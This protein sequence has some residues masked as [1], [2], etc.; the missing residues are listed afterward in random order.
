MGTL[1]KKFLGFLAILITVNA[2]IYLGF[3]LI[4]WN[5]HPGMWDGFMRFMMTSLMAVA[6]VIVMALYLDL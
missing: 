4:M 1:S 3:A 2:L 6:D 5:L